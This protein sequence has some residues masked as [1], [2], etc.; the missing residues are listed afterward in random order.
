[1]LSRWAAIGESKIESSWQEFQSSKPSTNRCSWNV[2]ELKC[3]WGYYFNFSFLVGDISINNGLSTR[4]SQLIAH[5]FALQPG[6]VSLFHFIKTWLKTQG[7]VEFKGYTLTL[8]VLFYLQ[9]EK[10][11]P[12]IESVQRDI[13]KETIDGKNDKLTFQ[14]LNSFSFAGW[15][16]QFNPN[17]TLADYQTS[18]IYNYKEHIRG[19]FKFYGDFDYSQVMST[20]CGRAINGHQ[21]KASFP[22]FLMKSFFLYVAGPCNRGTNCG[23]MDPPHKENF[24]RLCKASSNFLTNAGIWFMTSKC[25]LANIFYY[26][27]TNKTAWYESE[28]QFLSNLLVETCQQ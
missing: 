21:Y 8:L 20:F 27:R 14:V 18:K 2:S 3:L 5:L 13:P 28:F 6:A 23:I 19:F 7:F 25:K 9:Q 26:Y 4:N 10:L 11:M 12:T 17:L 15:Q 22:K 16:V 24:V 1:M